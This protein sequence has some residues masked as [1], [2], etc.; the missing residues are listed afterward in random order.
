MRLS[1][2]GRIFLYGGLG[3]CVLGRVQGVFWVFC[4][5]PTLPIIPTIPNLPSAILFFKTVRL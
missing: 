2:E 4:G 3:G 1:S 5:L